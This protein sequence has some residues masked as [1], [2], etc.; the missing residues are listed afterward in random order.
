MLEANAQTQNEFATMSSSDITFITAE[1][2]SKLV[3]AQRER[4]KAEEVKRIAEWKRHATR[5]ISSCADAGYSSA[6]IEC[7]FGPSAMNEIVVY[8]EGLGYKVKVEHMEPG[9]N[10]LIS[11]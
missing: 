1:E 4:V 11:W 8:L 7:D 2:A 10:L 6:R 3:H 5:T 9:V